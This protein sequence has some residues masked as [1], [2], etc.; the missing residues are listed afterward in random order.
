MAPPANRPPGGPPA[1]GRGAAPRAR[2][3]TAAAGR[4]AGG[5]PADAGHLRITAARRRS[6]Q[7]AV[8]A[9]IGRLLASAEALRREAASAGASEPGGL[10]AVAGGLYT[11]AVEEYGKLLLLEGL[12][13]KGGIVSVPHAEIFRRHGKKFKAA[14]EALPQECRW[15]GRGLFDPAIFDPRIFDTEAAEATFSGR[16][17]LLYTDIGRTGNPRV[18]RR[19]D[20]KMLEKALR[21]LERAVAEWEARGGAEPYTGGE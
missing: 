16:T 11:Y 14:H 18:A 2:A 21:G 5:A 20:A 6:M 15:L 8:L 9:G 12:P 7:D 17:S 4:G 1:D 19:P 13:E 10:L 3:R